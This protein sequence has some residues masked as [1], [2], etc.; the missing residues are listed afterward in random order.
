M[1]RIQFRRDTSSNWLKYNPILMEGEVGY[2]IDTKKRKIGDGYTSWINLS[3]LVAENISQE[4]GDDENTVI[5]QKVITSLFNEGYLYK[6]VATTDTEISTPIGKIFYIVTSPGIYTNFGNITIDE[7]LNIVKWDG[8][9]WTKD[10]IELNI[11]GGSTEGL[12]EQIQNLTNNVGILEYE[13]FN[14]SDSYEIGDVVNYNGI[15]YVFTKPHS[16]GPWNQE[17]VQN[18]NL[19][20]ELENQLQSIKTEI[21]KYVDQNIEDV[22]TDISELDEAVFPLNISVSA[23]PTLIEIKKPTFVT[24]SWN[25]ERKNE[26]ITNDCEIKLNN[27]VVEGT[28]TIKQFNEEFPANVRLIITANY[29]SMTATSNT[30]IEFVAP[31]YFGF[32]LSTNA[33]DLQISELIKQDLSSTIVGEYNLENST[34][35][36]YMWLCVPEDKTIKEVTLNGFTVPMENFQNKVENGITYKCYRSNHALVE[37]NYIIKIY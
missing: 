1:D 35:D 28:S 22:K 5:S 32:S 13:N 27:E 6:G 17:E 24:I 10:E 16:A 2:E 26:D 8:V 29:N 34:G 33:D 36:A 11:S 15:L 4:L 7:G 25:V 30:V 3:Y 23:D 12:L 9:S 37:N 21:I 20:N 31:V 18:T 19:K 14:E